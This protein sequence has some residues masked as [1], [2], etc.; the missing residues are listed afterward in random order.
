MIARR[1]G[2]V[3]LAVAVSLAWMGCQPAG[4]PP[5]EN[6]EGRPPVQDKARSKPVRLKM[7]DDSIRVRLL[8]LETVQKDLGL[9]PNQIGKI[10][11]LGK[12]SERR[13]RE[14][15]AK[16]RE[17]L[18]PSRSFTPEEAEARQRES[19][20]LFADWKSQVKESRTQP[21]R[22]TQANSAPD[23]NCGCSAP[24]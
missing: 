22:A 8:V 19:L 17:I 9:T 23:G 13:S 10:K 2:L 3:V 18:P 4:Q 15:N 11:D 12:I 20:A 14:F 5:L 16:L 6:Q 24:A 21:K 7:D 1:S